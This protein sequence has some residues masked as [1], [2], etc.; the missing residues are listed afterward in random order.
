MYSFIGY[1]ADLMNEMGYD[2]KIYS[3]YTLRL[4]YD[5][6]DQ[7]S[8]HSGY[9]ILNDKVELQQSFFTEIDYNI[10]QNIPLVFG[11]ASDANIKNLSWSFIYTGIGYKGVLINR[12]NFKLNLLAVFNPLY[13]GQIK[14]NWPLTV[15]L[16]TDF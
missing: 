12:N 1:H 2:S 13:A 5:I 16:S 8:L 11:Y 9:S 6:N 4:Q 15:L 3:M 7:F 14:T 10:T